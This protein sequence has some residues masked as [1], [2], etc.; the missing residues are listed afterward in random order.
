MILDK[1][2]DEPKR[3]EVAAHWSQGEQME[4][5]VDRMLDVLS[6]NEVGI[7]TQE[8]L[9]RAEKVDHFHGGGLQATEVLRSLMKLPSDV[10]R[11]ADIGSGLGGPMRWF[12]LNTGAS[13]DG[14]DATPDF[15]QIANRIS[16]RVN[17]SGSCVARVGDARD[18]PL[19]AESYDF[20]TMMALSCNVPERD[21]L[22]SSTARILK[23]NGVVGMLDIIKGPT[24][25]LQLP[26]PWSRDGARSISLLLTRTETIE[27]ANDAGL[28]CDTAE[29]VSEL[30]L[31]WFKRDHDEMVGGR[32]VGFEKFLPDWQTM[33][34]SQIMNL[35]REHIK[36]E[37]LV[38]RKSI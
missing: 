19:P 4:E 10:R 6:V 18:I 12:A 13:M 9:E 22:Y 37:C 32:E 17:M 11:G 15:V 14:V 25:G 3:T 30:V 28:I 26:V 29:D 5:Q 31:E 20:A 2:K 33:V 23:D 38:F 8:R 7:T 35:E 27:V 24:K 16:Q 1:I 21:Q 34:S 36:F